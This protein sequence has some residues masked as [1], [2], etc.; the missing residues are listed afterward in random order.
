MCRFLLVTLAAVSTVAAVTPALAQD[1]TSL[2]GFRIEAVAGWDNFSTGHGNSTS[3]DDIVWG[4]GAGYD[5][6][7]GSVVIGAEGEVTWTG[8]DASAFGVLNPADALRLEAA[9]DLYIGARVGVPFTPQLLGYVKGG[10]TNLLIESTY[11]P[12]NLGGVI[13]EASSDTSGY[14]FGAGIEYRVNSSFSVKGEY[15]YSHYSAIG[16]H[17]PDFNID[18]DRNQIL[19]GVGFHF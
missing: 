5:F 4:F 10:Y 11:Y 18:T 8:V 17:N 16:E 19:V 9:R 6:Q 12:A 1:D 2:T 3:K 15:R 13:E 7:A 14:R